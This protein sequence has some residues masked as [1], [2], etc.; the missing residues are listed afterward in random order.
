TGWIEPVAKVNPVTALLNGAR[1]LMAGDP[2][3]ILLAYGIAFGMIA[4]LALWALRG[5]RRAEVAG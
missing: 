5:L 4:L 3:G 1:S 2:T